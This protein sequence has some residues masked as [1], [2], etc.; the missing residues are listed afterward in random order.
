VEG[1][2]QQP[3]TSFTAKPD[4]TTN[5]PE[6]SN[7]DDA[8]LEGLM[9]GLRRDIQRH[10][11]E[12]SITA[13]LARLAGMADLP[14]TAGHQSPEQTEYRFRERRAGLP[15]HRLFGPIPRSP[16]VRWSLSS[17]LDNEI[18]PNYAADYRQPASHRDQLW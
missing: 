14:P 5:S 12:A 10:K 18:N 15:D 4:A 1:G 9:A 7:P 8:S 13:R 11:L 3:H 6:S 2:D 16:S 17:V